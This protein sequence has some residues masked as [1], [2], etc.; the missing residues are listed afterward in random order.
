MYEDDSITHSFGLCYFPESFLSCSRT[1]VFVHIFHT[2]NG[3]S[4]SVNS[5]GYL[6]SKLFS[7]EYNTPSLP[8]VSY[9][10]FTG[11]L[12]CPYLRVRLRFVFIHVSEP[13]HIFLPNKPFR[14][15][16]IILLVL[17]TV[18]P[19]SVLSLIFPKATTRFFKPEPILI[20]SLS[21]KIL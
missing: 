19:L 6:E 11:L 17:F 21:I 4:F 3:R 18:T 5:G 8:R 13:R 1:I 10:Y 16:Q 14:E 12:L 2:E 20:R 7:D 9:E 15:R